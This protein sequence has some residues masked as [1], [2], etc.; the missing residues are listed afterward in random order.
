[1][2]A[3]TTRDYRDH[4]LLR[5]AGIEALTNALGPAGM[6]CF[7]RQFDRGDGDYTAER[8]KLLPGATMDDILAEVKRR[9][10]TK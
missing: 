1:M 10:Q 8:E 4:N 2:N 6:A 9:E 5:K 7:I 3:D